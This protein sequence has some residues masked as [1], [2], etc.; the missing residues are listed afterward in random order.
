M[1]PIHKLQSITV[2]QHYT[3][4]EMI[5]LE[6]RCAQRFLEISQYQIHVT[7]A[8]KHMVFNAL[9]HSV[10]RDCAIRGSLFYLPFMS[11]FSLSELPRW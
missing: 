4:Q 2:V 11:Q 3:K 6:E 7:F 5:F 8:L 10:H 1:H 9:S